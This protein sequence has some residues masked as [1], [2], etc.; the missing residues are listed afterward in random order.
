MHL[1]VEE[2]AVVGDDVQQRNAVVRRGPDCGCA[3]EKIAVTA[4]THRQPSR[5]LERQCGADRDA[6]SAAD[7]A[8]AIGA[9]ERQW[10]VELP[11]CTIPPERQVNERHVV[12]ADHF[13]QSGREMRHGD[14]AIDEPRTRGLWAAHLRRRHPR[15]RPRRRRWRC[16]RWRCRRWR[17]RRRRGWRRRVRRALRVLLQL[18]EQRRDHLIRLRCDQHVDQR[19]R[20]VIHAPASVQLMILRDLNNRR[21]WRLVAECRDQRA[22]EIDP[23]EADDDIGVGDDLPRFRYRVDTGRACMQF[24]V[25]RECCAD[26][27]IGDDARADRFGE[28]NTITPALHVARHTAHQE[29]WLGRCGERRCE[30][31]NLFCGCAC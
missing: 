16:R 19:Q 29:Y 11:E 13:V 1:V 15:L 17:C 2:R 24:M 25:R 30:A 18:F 8:T 20:L 6:R 23:I 3:H 26:F 12:A 10:M 27:Q 7:A 31:R 4:D 9:D 5:A 14:R 28:T 22:T 21:R